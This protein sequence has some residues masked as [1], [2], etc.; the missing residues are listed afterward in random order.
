MEERY[1]SK[2]VVKDS[3]KLLKDATPTEVGI[4]EKK[5]TEKEG[6]QCIVLILQ[7]TKF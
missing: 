7:S 1:C 6:T 3:P 4:N 5:S 2:T